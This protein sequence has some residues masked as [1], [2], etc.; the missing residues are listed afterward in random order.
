MYGNS[1]RLNNSLKVS[2]D[3][4]AFTSTII[5]EV[6]EMISFLGYTNEDFLLLLYGVRRSAKYSYLPGV[7]RDAGFASGA[8]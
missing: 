1:E 2:I 8:E 5:T 4:I 6:S 3:W 7:Y